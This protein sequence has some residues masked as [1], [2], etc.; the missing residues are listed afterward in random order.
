MH[1]GVDPHRHGVGV[2]A[3][4]PGVHVEEVAVLLLDGLRGRAGPSRR[5][6]RGRRRGGRPRPRGRRRGPRRRR[7]WPGGRRCRGGPGCRTPGRSARGSSRGP[8]RGC[9]AGPCRSRPCFFGTQIRPSLRSDSLI[10]V[11]FDWW[12]PGDRDAGRVDLR[13]AG[14]RHVGALAV[15][16][17]GRGDVAAHGVGG[18]EEDVAVAAAGQ[19]HDVG[20]VGLDLAGH[21]VADDDAAGPAVDD[22]QLE[23]LVPRVAADRAGGDLPLE[24]L[25]G[26]DQQLLAGLAAGVERPRHLDAAEG[27][28][29]E[30]AAVLAGERDALR[31]ALVDDV[32]ADLGQPVDVGLARAVVAALDGVVEEPVDGVAVALVVLGRVDAALGGDRVRP[33]RAV[34]V[35]E[36]L[37]DVP[38]LAERGGRRGAGQTR[39]D[40]DHRQPATVGRVGD[41]GLE[42]AGVP[43]LVERTA[44]RLGV[45]DR[46]TVDVVAG[47]VVVLL[48]DRAAGVRGVDGSWWCRACRPV[49]NWLASLR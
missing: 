31:D 20:E 15:R 11:S 7:S 30:Q 35:A 36:R 45:G 1:G 23:H 2:L 28:V 48:V 47:G 5:R 27:A 6:S 18:E 19:H 9:P 22:D 12:P 4:D 24:G 13:V 42:L 38:G 33:A 14:V 3:G 29:V 46:V 37:H 43:P 32:H 44:G 39:A 8:P 41:P 17:P 10:S 40:H 26:A 21:Q 49:A 34:L 25:V 16:P